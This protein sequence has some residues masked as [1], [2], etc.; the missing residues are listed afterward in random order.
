MQRS[1]G[2]SLT[3]APF[4]RNRFRSPPRR[5]CGGCATPTATKAFRWRVSGRR[6]DSFSAAAHAA[7]CGGSRK[8]TDSPVP[9]PY[10]RFRRAP[11]RACA[12]RRYASP[13]S[14]R[15]QVSSDQKP[16]LPAADRCRLDA[17]VPAGRGPV[18]QPAPDRAH[19]RAHRF[20]VRHHARLRTDRCVLASA[21]RAADRR[22]HRR[23]RAQQS[24]APPGRNPLRSRRGVRPARRRHPRASAN[25]ARRERARQPAGAREA[26]DARNPT[27][28]GRSAAGIRSNGSAPGATRS[29]RR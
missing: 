14:T 13:Q 12:G 8:Q 7:G 4:P 1:V 18:V 2:A 3:S 28:S 11:A 22:E 17:P 21:P 5:R 29:R 6:C 25:R 27:A 19:G 26:R 23:R 24:P 9:S 16:L 20:R 15:R 10:S